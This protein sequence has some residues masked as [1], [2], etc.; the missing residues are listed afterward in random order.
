MSI[1]RKRS[2]SKEEHFGVVVAVYG[3]DDDISQ[4]ETALPIQK[5]DILQLHSAPEEVSLPMLCLRKINLL[6]VAVYLL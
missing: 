2:V 6:T 1:E 4:Y 5:G 3:G